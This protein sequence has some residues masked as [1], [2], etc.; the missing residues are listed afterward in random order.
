MT[1][2]LSAEDEDVGRPLPQLICCFYPELVLI[3][4]VDLRSSATAQGPAG[5]GRTAAGRE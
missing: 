2:S 3:V 1:S 5:A 4:V